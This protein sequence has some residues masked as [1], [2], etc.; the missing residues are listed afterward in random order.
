MDIRGLNLK[1]LKIKQC[2][3]KITVNGRGIFQKGEG[4]I[5][6]ILENIRSR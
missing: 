6:E 1:E 2:R 4:K 5:G 3:E